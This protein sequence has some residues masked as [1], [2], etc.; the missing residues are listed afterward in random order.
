MIPQSIPRAEADPSEDELGLFS[1]RGTGSRMSS[2]LISTREAS[3]VLS[4]HNRI[5]TITLNRP[6]KLNAFDTT[7]IHSLS[8]ALGAVSREEETIQCVLL[9]GAGRGFC[10]GADLDYLISL[11]REN[12]L[13]EFRSLLEGGRRVVTRLRQ[14]PMPVIAVVNGPA[15][16]GGGSLAMVKPTSDSSIMGL[17]MVV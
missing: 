9:T 3:I 5:A 13:E 16:G 1:K 12:R 6:E 17:P 8:D 2:G 7:M 4:K 10:S 14:M 11:R 15:A